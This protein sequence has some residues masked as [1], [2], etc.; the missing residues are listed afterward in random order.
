MKIKPR[1]AMALAAPAGAGLTLA[2]LGAA[3]LILMIGTIG[4]GAQADTLSNQQ[5][6][7]LL[8]G[9]RRGREAVRTCEYAVADPTAYG[10]C[11][12]E[13]IWR[14][15]TNR[16]GCL[17]AVPG[18]VVQ[19]SEFEQF[20]AES[21][22]RPMSAMPMLIDRDVNKYFRG[23]LSRYCSFWQVSCR[24]LV[25]WYSDPRDAL[26]IKLLKMTAKP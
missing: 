6:Q 26:L 15:N 5:Y 11:V 18:G 8:A 9:F 3:V 24:E 14:C 20:V 13:V 12:N 4:L 1:Q 25:S 23:S 19:G 7:G 22:V 2:L 21:R 16:T 10:R 17:S